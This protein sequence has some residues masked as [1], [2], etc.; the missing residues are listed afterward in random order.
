MGCH[1]KMM[2]LSF[3]V[4]AFL[5]CFLLIPK[6]AHAQFFTGPIASS[7]GGAG[8][9]AL[10]PSEA[11]ILNPAAVAH[12]RSYYIGG[13]YAYGHH[14][15][16]GDSRSFGAIL[17]DGTEG[18]A[19]PGSLSI[20]HRVNE[21]RG[22]AN[23]STTLDI[24]I[25][26]ATFI[27]ERISIGASVHRQADEVSNQGNFSQYNGSI[28]ILYTPLDYFGIGAVVYDLLPPGESNPAIIQTTQT[29]AVGANLLIKK[30]LN[31]RLDVSRPDRNNPNH[32]NNI[33]TGLDT[34][35]RPDFAVRFGMLFKESVDETYFTAGLGYKGPKLS[36]DY[37][38]QKDVRVADSYR[39]MFD[40]WIPF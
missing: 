24:S 15:R 17:S 4:L 19:F 16:D 40:L 2:K 5:F 22:G 9:A 20:Q 32:R 12:L 39:H 27:S 11:G 33:L 37:T 7:V 30:L 1:I 35:F 26:A 34:Y 13:N 28:G 10:D 23:S 18:N 6:T 21:P 14:E 3:S 36:V 29:Y 25:A 31:V 8:I 38:F